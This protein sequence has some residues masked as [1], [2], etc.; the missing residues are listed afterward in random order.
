MK[1]DEIQV[2][3]WIDIHAPRQEVFDII[4][5]LERRSQLSPLWGMLKIEHIDREYPQ[6]GSQITTR[7]GE[8]AEIF[9]T[10]IIT[11]LVP[12]FKFSYHTLTDRET[13]VSW[14]FQDVKTGT[15]L[16]YFE[17]FLAK[18]GD[19]EEFTQKIHKI[20]KEWLV[21]IKR[22]A[23]LRDTRLK[24]LVRWFLDRYYL[25][26]RPDQR[27]TVQ[28]ILFMHG[29]AMIAFVMAALAYGF[30]SFLNKAFF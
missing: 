28:V 23:E 20:V 3:E 12:L 13:Q 10:T 26:M 29:V 24:R 14:T 7:L 5:D 27:R 16:T 6:E 17:K 18:D 22:Y 25:R 2:I 4:I 8:N 9:R 21:N 19:G 11:D 30:A 1:M 15:R